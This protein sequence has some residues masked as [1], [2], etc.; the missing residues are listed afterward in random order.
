MPVPRSSRSARSRRSVLRTGLTV[1]L[2]GL[3][4]G[5]LGWLASSWLAGSLAAQLGPPSGDLAWYEELP[6]QFYLMAKESDLKA[7]SET[8]AGTSFEVQSGDTVSS[9]ADRLHASGWMADPVLFRWYLRYTGGDR[10]LVPGIYVLPPGASARAIADALASGRGR[11]RL[12]TVLPGMRAEEISSLLSGA[13][14]A[15]GP[16]DFLDAIRRRPGTPRCTPPS[17]PSLPWKDSC[18]PTPTR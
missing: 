10:H 12:L 5:A 2:A 18:S 16:Q 11:I 3:V 9:L 13:G 8:S 17:L 6:V 4:C 14:L 1:V 7:P 15:I